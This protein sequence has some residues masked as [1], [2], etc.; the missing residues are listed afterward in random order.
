MQ[1]WDKC[2]INFKKINEI[3]FQT[4][5]LEV[6]LLYLVLLYYE[7]NVYTKEII[8]IKYEWEP[9]L[10]ITCLIFGHSPVDCP[11]A[12]KFAPTRVVNQKDN[13]KFRSS[14]ADDEGSIKLKKKKSSGNNDGIKN[15]VFFIKPKTQYRSK[16]IRSHQAIK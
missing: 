10:C 8:R 13:G 11:K 14:G 7:V 1:L 6:V 9:L 5:H 16:A 4:T 2:Y 12:L 3:T 15:F